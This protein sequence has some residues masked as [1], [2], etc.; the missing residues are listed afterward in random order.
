MAPRRWDWLSFQAAV[1]AN[2]AL[3]FGTEPYVGSV[4]VIRSGGVP[5]TVSSNQDRIVVCRPD[6]VV[7]SEDAPRVRV[8]QAPSAP[9]LVTIVASQYAALVTRNATYVSTISG[10]GLA[11]PAAFTA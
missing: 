11:A 4:R 2:D 7:F 10:V 6:S 5:L 9:Q 1:T 3:E 8:T